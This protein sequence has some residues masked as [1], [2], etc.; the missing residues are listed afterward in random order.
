MNFYKLDFELRRKLPVP[1]Y[2]ELSKSELLLVPILI[3]DLT[4]DM[5]YDDEIS[6]AV[7]EQISIERP[8]LIYPYFEHIS[9]LLF[10]KIDV[11]RWFAFRVLV[12][13]LVCDNGTK[14]QTIEGKY[15][16]MLLSSNFP[17]FNSALGCTAKILRAFPRLK[18][19]IVD[20][21][22]DVDS[23][24]FFSNGKVIDDLCAI[25]SD[26]VENLLKNI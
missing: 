21:L 1:H 20:T 16:E 3:Q 19:R 24:K 22:A 11:Y 9:K 6:T 2:I 5:F 7:I 26:L 4:T 17:A 13:T 12:N 23:R 15:F 14:W 10:S 8:E 25:A 18:D